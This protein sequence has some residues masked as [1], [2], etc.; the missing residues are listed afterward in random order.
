MLV[1]RFRSPR[2]AETQGLRETQDRKDLLARKVLRAY[3]GSQG[4]KVLRVLKVLRGLR[5]G[6]GPGH[7]S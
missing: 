7:P 2:V 5:E 6:R 4:S 3:R 1:S